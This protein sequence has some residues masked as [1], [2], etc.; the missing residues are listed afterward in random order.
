MLDTDVI[1]SGLQSSVGASRLLLYAVAEGAFVPL[2]TVAT[3]L[4]HEDV[5]MRPECLAVTGLTH[6]ETA[7]F[8]DEYIAHSERVIVWRRTRPS[9]QDPSDEIFVEAVVNG[10]G[11]AIVT[12]NRRDYLDADQRLASQG[13]TVIPVISPGEALR[14]LA[15]RPTA[16]T[17]FVFPR[18]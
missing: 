7:D 14:R 17:P 4:E 1:R 11:D 13:R 10:R 5:L 8:L 16:T 6:Q 9:I 12:F 15:W 2:V 18:R 3:V